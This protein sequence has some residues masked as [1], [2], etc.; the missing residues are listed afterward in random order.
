MNDK[1]DTPSSRA[2][3]LDPE[4]ILR[5]RAR[6]LA[7]PSESAPSA[8]TRLD[9]LEF[10]LASERYAIETRFVREVHPLKELTPLPCTPAFVMGIVNLRGRILPVLDIKRFFGLPEQGLAD[11][12][13]ILFVH[14]NDLEF[15]LLADAVVGTLIL[16]MDKLQTP[17]PLAGM[18]ADYLRGVTTEGLAILN[19]DR[20]LTDPRIIVNED[21]EP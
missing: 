9:L 13:C 2:P 1:T 20:I 16:P 5:A 21:V 3:R 6:L 18:R 12:H 7:R 11:L 10:R 8:D 17:P 4:Q 14:G 15:G 19:L